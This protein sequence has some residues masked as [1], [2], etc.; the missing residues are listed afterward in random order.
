MLPSDPNDNQGGGFDLE[1]RGPVEAPVQDRGDSLIRLAIDK[2]VDMD[3]LQRLIDM[4]HEEEERQAKREFDAHF[5]LMQADFR[6]VARTKQGDKGKY[7]PLDELQKEYGPI[8]SRHGFSYRWS[9]E[10][11]AE[12]GLR[13]LLTVSGYGHSVTNYKDLPKYEPDKIGG[14]EKRIMN[15]MQAEGV[16]SSYGRRYTFIAG[17]GL[18]IEDEDTDASFEDGVKY[19]DVVLQI[20]SASKATLLDVW[21]AV[22]EQYK[23]DSRAL[24]ILQAEYSKR[25]KE[26]RL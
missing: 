19:S 11:I 23:T 25:K 18:I 21:K 20:Q 22:Y 2:N 8:I 6:P 7:A 26:L 3:R 10:P 9:E 14:T 24:K 17:F 15:A 12:G 5:A 4:K 16:R 1:T 13:V